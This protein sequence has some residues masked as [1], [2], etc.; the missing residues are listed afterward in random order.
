MML[1]TPSEV[2]SFHLIIRNQGEIKEITVQLCSNVDNLNSHPSVYHYLY[3]LSSTKLIAL[4]ART[5]YYPNGVGP[6]A[7]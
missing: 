2:K 6:D 7:T 1:L 3:V 5:I 4:K